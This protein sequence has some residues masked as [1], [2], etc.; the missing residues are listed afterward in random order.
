MEPSLTPITTTNGTN[1]DQHAE[2]A[3]TATTFDPTIFRDYLTALLPPVIGASLHEL[4]SLFDDDF[5]ER[6]VKFAAEGAEAI[7]IVKVR[8]ESEGA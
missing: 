1:H 2:P 7:Y 3:T 4:H 5:D 6:V 8:D